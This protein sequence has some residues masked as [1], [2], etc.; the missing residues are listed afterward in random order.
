MKALVLLV[1]IMHIHSTLVRGKCVCI[2]VYVCCVYAC[3][4]VVCMHVCVCLCVCMS[5]CVCVC[6]GVAVN[7]GLV[8]RSGESY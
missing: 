3:V 7:K 6:K 1:I 5:V 4:Y 2:C 8:G